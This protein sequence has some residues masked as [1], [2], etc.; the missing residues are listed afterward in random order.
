MGTL[1]PYQLTLRMKD[2]LKYTAG[3]L[4][5]GAILLTG[6]QFF[7]DNGTTLSGAGSGNCR[8]GTDAIKQIG[9]DNSSTVLTAKSNRA[10]AKIQMPSNATNTAAVSFDEGAAATLVSGTLLGE[11]NATTTTESITFGLNT[12]FPYTGAV[13]AITN[14]STTSVHVVECLYE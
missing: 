2:V 10:W 1:S 5:A 6:S 9:D 14:N 8:V 7:E 12:D 13:T 3:V 4:I 11:V